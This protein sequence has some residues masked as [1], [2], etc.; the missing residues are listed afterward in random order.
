MGKITKG[1]TP[2]RRPKPSKNH[3]KKMMKLKR[4]YMKLIGIGTIVNSNYIGKR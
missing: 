4:N 2:L 1:I 3:N